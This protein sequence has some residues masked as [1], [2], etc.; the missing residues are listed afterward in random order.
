M[1][2]PRHP[3]RFGSAGSSVRERTSDGGGSL[4]GPRLADRG[5]A[6]VA[7]R[8]QVVRPAA[9]RRGRGWQRLR[10][11]NMPV[12]GRQFSWSATGRQTP[13]GA[14]P[15]H[16]ARPPN[17]RKRTTFAS[18][19]LTRFSPYRHAKTDAVRNMA[20]ECRRQGGEVACRKRRTLGGVTGRIYQ[21]IAGE[22]WRL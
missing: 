20:H 18:L 17:A 3:G 21:H 12:L 6:V 2:P 10:H 11:R 13:N 1:E 7:E 5:Y 15:T 19:I 4:T 8:I 16:G 14:I 9:L 22:G